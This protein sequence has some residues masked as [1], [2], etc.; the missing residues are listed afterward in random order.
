MHVLVAG[1]SPSK[2]ETA[3]MLDHLGHTVSSCHD[4]PGDEC[5]ALRGESCPLEDLPIDVVMADRASQTSRCARRRAVPVIGTD[6][7]QTALATLLSRATTAMPRHTAVAEEAAR[8]VLNTADVPHGPL[9]ASVNRRS[10]GLLVTV[11]GPIGM[12]ASVRQR[13]S[14]RVHAAV[15]KL[16]H[17]ARSLDIV[18]KD[19]GDE[20]C[21][22]R[23]CAQFVSTPEPIIRSRWPSRSEWT[24]D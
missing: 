14:V 23:P 19:G 18:V 20:A 24:P 21:V 9:T 7:D 3:P 5:V 8:H 6:A 13:I 16:D 1:T 4:T 12:S 15:R 10:G 17:W 22:D 11:I 2:A